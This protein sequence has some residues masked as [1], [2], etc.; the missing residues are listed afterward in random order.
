MLNF[1]KIQQT[2]SRK[3][4]FRITFAVV[5]QNPKMS[6]FMEK[7]NKIDPKGVKKW[8]AIIIAVL[9]A[10]AGALG[11]SATGYVGGLLGL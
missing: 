6:M 9:S 1:V 5:N 8:I 7:E 2:L 3:S 10:I 4:L 11:E